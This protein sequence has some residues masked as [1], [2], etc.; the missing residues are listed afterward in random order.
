MDEYGLPRST[1]TPMNLGDVLQIATSPSS[2]ATISTNN[3]TTI[4]LIDN[5]GLLL[6]LT[7]A[8]P[9]FPV[10]LQRFTVAA[11]A[12]ITVLTITGGTVRGAL[13]GLAV[14]GFMTFRYSAI[15]GLW[16]RTA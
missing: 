2:G 4:M 9:A 16:F 3:N 8:L 14:G 10:D 11:N 5:P 13:A 7:V 1:F 6:A 15:L 12:A